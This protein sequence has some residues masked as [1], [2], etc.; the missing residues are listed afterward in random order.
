MIYLIALVSIAF[1]SV[2]QFCLKIGVSQAKQYTQTDY[3]LHLLTNLNFL[4]GLALYGLSMISWLFVLSKLELSKAYPMVSIGYVLT[5]AMACL[6]L[7][8]VL[9]W[10]RALGIGLI[11]LGVIFITRS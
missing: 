5:T 3:V 2:A 10:N 1:G 8:E 4:A 11:V 9:N 6:W 7:G